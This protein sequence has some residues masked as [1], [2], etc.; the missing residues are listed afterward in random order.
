MQPLPYRKEFIKYKDDLYDVIRKY[1]E[2]KIKPDMMDELRQ[3]LSCE[4]TLKK[5]GV[6]Y[7]CRKIDEAQIIQ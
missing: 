3:A 2:S 6:V 4:I 1:T 7:Y 5:D